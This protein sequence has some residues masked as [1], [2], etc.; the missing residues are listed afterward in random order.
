MLSRVWQ[1]ILG[2][3]KVGIHDNFFDLGGDS[4]ISLQVVEPPDPGRL[5]ACTRRISFSTRPFPNWPAWLKKPLPLRPSR[6][7]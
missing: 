2:L 1:E 7:R 5:H 6:D 3:D 4:I